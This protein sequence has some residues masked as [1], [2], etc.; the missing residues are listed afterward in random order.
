MKIIY[1][2]ISEGLD[3]ISSTSINSLINIISE[4]FDYSGDNLDYWNTDNILYCLGV[5]SSG[6]KKVE[7]TFKIYKTEYYPEGDK[8]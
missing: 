6:E 3:A 1:T 4:L 8:Q 2:A 7:L 5:D